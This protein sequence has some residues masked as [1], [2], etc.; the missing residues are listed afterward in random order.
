MVSPK[1]S[2]LSSKVAVLIPA[3]NESNRIQKV[4]EE[5]KSIFSTIV[6]VD[7]GSTDD[8]YQVARN[9]GATF[10]L[11][12]CLNFGQGSALTT[13]FK[14][15]L[16]T[17]QFD[18]LITFDADGQHRLNDAA[19]MALFAIEGNS[20]AVFGSRFLDNTQRTAMP[21]IRRAFLKLAVKFESCIY[22][23]KLTDSHN[24]LRV[25]SRRAC[26]AL[27]NASLGY[28]PCDRNSFIAL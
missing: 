17:C 23:F 11:R 16:E 15:C 14:F 21:K 3:Y 12:Q 2:V 6:V 26:A 24:G 18:F 13:G 8:T 4:I 19:E 28:G 22:G 27:T 10:V 1:S 9:A 7:D 25:L 20:D 5:C